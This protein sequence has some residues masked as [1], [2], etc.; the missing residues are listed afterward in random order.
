MLDIYIDADGC[1]VKDEV[2]R[3][4][5]RYRLRVYVVANRR[6]HVPLGRTIE[7]IIVPKG[8]DVTDDWIAR[9]IDA[10]DIVITADIPLADRCLKNGAR[11]LGTRGEEF[12]ED[13]IGSAMAAR[14]LMAHLRETGETAG[15][16][17]PMSSKNRSQFLSTLDE[18]VQ[19]IRRQARA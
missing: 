7:M 1:P 18:I 4:A 11:V 12:R 14:E 19:S 2:Y 6:M 10:D 3:V 16:P 15:G 13:S 17:A 8:F 9:H 5:A